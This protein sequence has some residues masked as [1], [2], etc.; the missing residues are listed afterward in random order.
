MSILAAAS[1]CLA[2]IQGVKSTAYFQNRVL[3]DRP[4]FGTYWEQWAR[5]AIDTPTERNVESSGRIQLWIVVEHPDFGERV[6][7]VVTLDDEETVHTMFFDRDV[8]V[9]WEQEGRL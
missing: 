9:R 2:T 7:R 4:Y 6:L 1:A 8:R 5:I 3:R